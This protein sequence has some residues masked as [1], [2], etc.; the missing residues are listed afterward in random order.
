MRR[1]LYLIY[2]APHCKFTMTLVIHCFI[3]KR[4]LKWCSIFV[5]SVF[6]EYGVISDFIVILNSALIIEGVIFID[7]RLILLT[8]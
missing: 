8:Y 1:L 7:L 4:D 3:K 6:S 2:I 5:C